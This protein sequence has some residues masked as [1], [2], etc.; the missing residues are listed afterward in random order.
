MFYHLPFYPSAFGNESR[1]GDFCIKSRIFISGTLLSDALLPEYPIAVFLLRVIYRKQCK[2]LDH[3]RNLFGN[4]R[5][6]FF[7]FV[8][9][10]FTRL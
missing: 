6:V 8:E 1:D 3:K 5:V 7:L 2:L 10:L 9:M 4:I